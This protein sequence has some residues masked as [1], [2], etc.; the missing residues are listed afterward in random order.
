MCYICSFA[1]IYPLFFS[2]LRAPIVPESIKHFSISVIHNHHKWLE[3]FLLIVK[4][5]VILQSTKMFFFNYWRGLE[6]NIY[7]FLQ[8]TPFSSDTKKWGK[9]GFQWFF[10]FLVHILQ[11]LRWVAILDNTEILSLSYL[12]IRV[13]EITSYLK[14]FYY[15]GVPLFPLAP[16][17]RIF[18][19]RAKMRECEG[20]KH[21]ILAF[22]L[23]PLPQ[24]QRR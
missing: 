3:S 19:Y 17:I 11:N 23:Y 9:K 20:F 7:F 10:F 8:D 1:L 13:M 18:N 4:V 16:A 2:L 14:G 24:S 5:Y 15:H 21:N 12:L 22:I 6:Y